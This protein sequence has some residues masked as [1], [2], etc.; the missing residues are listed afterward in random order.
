MKNA[1]VI[2]SIFFFFS[3]GKKDKNVDLIANEANTTPPYDTI[4]IDS[5]SAGA[6]SVDVARKIRMSSIKYQDSLKEN[7][8]KLE[9]EKL[10]K[11]EL[12]D[13]AKADKKL[14]DEKKKLE[15]EKKKET[16]P[17]EPKTTETATG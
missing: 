15:K 17:E 10:A 12:E 8:K 5:F 9:V 7:L 11:K 16:K 14:E 13:K 4:A 3:C 2:L 6:T 1:F